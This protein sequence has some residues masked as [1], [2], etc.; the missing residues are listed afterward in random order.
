MNGPGK[1]IIVSN[2]LPI[3][4][5]SMK[6]EKLVYPSSGGLVS[7]LAPILDDVGGCWVGWSPL[8]FDAGLFIGAYISH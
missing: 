2:R 4:V 7:A 1:L 3:P 6:S 5:E 8:G